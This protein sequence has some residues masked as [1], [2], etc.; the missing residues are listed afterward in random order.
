MG[1]TPQGAGV[2][3]G[4]AGGCMAAH[5]ASHQVSVGMGEKVSPLRSPQPLL[6]L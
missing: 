6:N 1:W 2:G 3:G 5:Q 4:R